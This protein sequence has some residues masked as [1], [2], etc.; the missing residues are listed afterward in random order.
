MIPIKAAGSHVAVELA[1]STRGR[2][3][4]ANRAMMLQ[5]EKPVDRIVV[6]KSSTV[7]RY[8]TVIATEKI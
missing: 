4:I 6:G 3:I 5:Q 8:I 7:K 2:K 1:D